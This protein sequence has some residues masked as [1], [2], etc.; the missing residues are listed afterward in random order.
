MKP[1]DADAEATLMAAAGPRPTLAS[2]FAQDVNR[3]LAFTFEAEGLRLDLSKQRLSREHLA[4][5]LAFARARDI[6]A[7]RDA[8][9]AGAVVNPTEGRAALHPA[10]RGFGGG[11]EAQAQVAAARAQAR[12]FKAAFDADPRLGGAE[13]IEAIVHLGTGG[14]DLGPRLVLD[15]LKAYRRPGLQVRFAANIDPEDLADALDGLNPRRT[16]LIVASK[17]FT[18]LET[19]ANGAVARTW[20]QEAL[21]EAEAG[22]RL[23]AVTAKPAVA[24]AWGVAEEAIFP[25]W[26]WVGGRYSL[27]SA[28]SLAA[29]LALKPGVFD[30]L[31]AGARGMDAHFAETPLDANLPVL[32]ALVA[33]WNRAILGH[34]STATIVYAHRLRLLVDWLQ[35]L[36]ME[37]NGKGVDLAGAGLSAPAAGVTWGGVGASAQ[38]SFFQLLHQ[39]VQETPLDILVL[40]NAKTD[41]PSDFTALNANALAQARALFAGKDQSAV[42]AELAGQSAAAIAALAPHKVFRGDRATSLL[43]LSALTPHTLG[44]LLAFFEHRTVT[45]AW[46]AGVNPFDQWGV[47]LG[48]VMAASL[49][50]SLQGAESHGLDPSTAAWVERL[51]RL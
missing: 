38:H 12:A 49:I 34:S 21:G 45:Q 32:A 2:L 10:L 28:V 47:E 26:D 40:E 14:S 29:E 27:W 36:E 41:R 33:H 11:A 51:R 43:S 35:Q 20:L 39:G 30:A 1:R 13:P 16:L 24:K 48:K 5:L 22:R 31:L 4:A 50:G 46:L 23:V 7:G 15:A 42:E 6:E 3:A 9:F 8:L 44:A 19:M 25:F 37:S 17:T 18:T